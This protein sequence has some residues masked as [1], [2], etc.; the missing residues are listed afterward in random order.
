MLCRNFL[1]IEPITRQRNEG[2]AVSCGLFIVLAIGFASTKIGAALCTLFLKVL[3]GLG[4][5]GFALNVLVERV[6]FAHDRIMA[7]F[8]FSRAAFVGVDLDFL[9]GGAGLRNEFATLFLQLCE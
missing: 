4:N 5:A 1:R 8:E 6:Q 7:G 9:K 3:F 2:I